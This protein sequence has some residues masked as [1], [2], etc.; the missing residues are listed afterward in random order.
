MDSKRLSEL[1]DREFYAALIFTNLLTQGAP[2][3]DPR[4]Q[5]KNAVDYAEAL[6]NALRGEAG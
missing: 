4:P 3:S 5:A 2:P 1:T 6:V